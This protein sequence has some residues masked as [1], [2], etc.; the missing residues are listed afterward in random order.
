MSGHD[1]NRLIGLHDKSGTTKRIDFAF[2]SMT[3]GKVLKA[4][5]ANAARW[6]ALRLRARALPASSA[7]IFRPA[8]YD[9]LY[10]YNSVKRR[11]IDGIRTDNGDA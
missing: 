10:R 7:G 2:C 5:D 9:R 4:N 8:H 3:G 1:F 11:K 6:G